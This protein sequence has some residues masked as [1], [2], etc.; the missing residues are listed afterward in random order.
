MENRSR[1]LSLASRFWAGAADDA[2]DNDDGSR[3]V[4]HPSSERTR[5]RWHGEVPMS[6]WVW[7][8][9]RWVMVFMVG[10]VCVIFVGE[11][12]LNEITFQDLVYHYGH[13]KVD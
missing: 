6:G 4:T 7:S 9:G 5:Y 13:E 1:G 2:D 10:C 8:R 12:M 3:N 11:R